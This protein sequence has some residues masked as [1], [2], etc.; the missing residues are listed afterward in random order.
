MGKFSENLGIVEFVIIQPYDI[1]ILTLFV[2]LIRQIK[3]YVVTK[4]NLFT[5]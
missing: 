4:Q 3:D 5:L 1:N 2:E